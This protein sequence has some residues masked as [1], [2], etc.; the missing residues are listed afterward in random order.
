MFSIIIPLFNKAPYI[1]KAIESIFS[2]TFR[3]FEIIV[4]DDGSTDTGL[5]I[6]LDLIAK[7]DPSFILFRVVSQNNQG[8]S[9]ARNNGVKAANY[10]FIAFLDADD[11]WAP[12]YLFEMK[13]LID[14]FPYG[15]LYGSSYYKVKN[16]QF[17]RANIGV[18]AKFESG[19]INYCAVYSKTM[20]Q[21]I[22]T[23][24]A[25][26]RKSIFEFEN[27]FKSSLKL[28]EDFDLWL[29]VA[30][31]HK[32]I[33]L[34]KPLAFYNQDCELVHRATGGS[35][36]ELDQNMLF[37]DYSAY[38]SDT[39]FRQIY[40][41]LALYGLLNY[42]LVDKHSKQVTDILNGIDW[43]RHSFKYKMYY[44]ILPKIVV[45]IWFDFLKIA[46]RMKSIALRFK[47]LIINV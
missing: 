8:V 23:G 32:V 44:L 42:Y 5:E 6:V 22:W 12:D 41:V 39:Y 20:Y 29:R 37:S 25:I 19:P 14:C 28:G 13:Q 34:N 46:S 3:K 47:L 40:E 26:I 30:M 31:K 11:W 36:Y 33:L 7:F 16:K 9:T 17:I 2:Q 27:G 1:T 45:E 15:A 18:E 38:S 35:L 43:S 24:A 4:V 21:P 10:E